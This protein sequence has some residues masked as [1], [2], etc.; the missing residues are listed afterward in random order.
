MNYLVSD[1][2]TLV[3]FCFTVYTITALFL[4]P[5]MVRTMGDAS[6]SSDLVKPTSQA[7]PIDKSHNQELQFASRLILRLALIF[8]MVILLKNLV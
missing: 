5:N 2:N 7:I 1:K 3:W 8:P 6:P 4:V